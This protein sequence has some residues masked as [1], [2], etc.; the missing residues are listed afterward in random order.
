MSYW[1]RAGS[2]WPDSV[3]GPAEL[4]VPDSRRQLCPG[5]PFSRVKDEEGLFYSLIKDGIY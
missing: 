2:S 5:L 3:K 4:G 1:S